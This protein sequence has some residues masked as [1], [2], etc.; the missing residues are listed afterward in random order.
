[1]AWESRAPIAVLAVRGQFGRIEPEVGLV[2]LEAVLTETPP[3]SSGPYQ[4]CAR[5][6]QGGSELS[7]VSPTLFGWCCKIAQLLRLR[8]S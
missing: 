1:V 5:I 2:R 4:N 3:I 8:S 7:A 6:P